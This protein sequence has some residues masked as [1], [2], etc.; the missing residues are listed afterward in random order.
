SEGSTQLVS[1]LRALAS[2]IWSA[3]ATP[4]QEAALV[5]FS[6]NTQM[7]LYVQRSARIHGHVAARLYETLV[8]LGVPC[9][10][11][12]GAFYLYPDFAPWRSAL[13][14]RGI[15]TSQELAHYLLDEWDI[16]TL[17]G[18]VFGEQPEALR[19]RMATSLLYDSDSPQ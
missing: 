4:I 7:E 12:A 2:E 13:M 3:A 9:P 16:A 10:R 8:N 11:P 5:A 18:M 6:A 14:Q 1:A 19:L 15:G 17:P